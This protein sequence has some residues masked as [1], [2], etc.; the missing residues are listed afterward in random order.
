MHTAANC[1][2]R[3][4]YY[5][6]NNTNDESNVRSRFCN[7][8]RR[9]HRSCSRRTCRW[10][11]YVYCIG[12]TATS[13]SLRLQ[14]RGG[15]QARCDEGRVETIHSKTSRYCVGGDFGWGFRACVDADAGSQQA[16]EHNGT[17]VHVHNAVYADIGTRYACR[18]CNGL[19][20]LELFIAVELLYG[21]GKRHSHLHHVACRLRR[22]CCRRLRHCLTCRRQRHLRRTF[23]R[24]RGRR[25]CI[26]CGG[27]SQWQCCCVWQ[28]RRACSGLQKWCRCCCV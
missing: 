7:H 25:N 6:N 1:D 18:E 24:C 10:H 15:G 20:E 17:A 3:N 13:V 4:Q 26:E 5:H 9:R 12:W 8:G 2:G 14:K 21:Q 19:L 11:A 27:C 22:W 23:R 28:W 16:P